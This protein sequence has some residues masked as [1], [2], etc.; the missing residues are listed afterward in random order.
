MKGKNNMKNNEILE[1][2]VCLSEEKPVFNDE[3]KAEITQIGQI[4]DNIK[5]VKEYVIKLNEYYS[6]L[7]Y[8]PENISEAKE[9]KSKINKFKDK[10]KAGLDK[11]K[12][13]L[14]TISTL[15]YSDE[16]LLE[17]KKTKDLSTSISI[18]SNRHKELEQIQKS[19]VKV[20]NVKVQNEEMLNKVTSSLTAPKEEKISQDEI[21]EMTFKVRGTKEKLKELVQFIKDGGYDYE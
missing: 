1:A 17:Y 4:E 21:L 2:K 16:I 11:L 5:E 7:I 3:I 20:D 12:N 15:N 18:V 9:D 14:D 19:S 8:T 13:E 10:V 6:K